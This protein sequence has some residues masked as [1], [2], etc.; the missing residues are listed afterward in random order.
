MIRHLHPGS[1]SIAVQTPT[2]LRLLCVFN[3]T[4]KQR[5]PWAFLLPL[6]VLPLC[7]C[8]TL[9]R[10]QPCV[11]NPGCTASVHLIHSH[12]VG[13]L[14]TCQ[15]GCINQQVRRLYTAIGC[16]PYGIAQDEATL[17]ADAEHRWCLFLTTFMCRHYRMLACKLTSCSLCVATT[18]SSSAQKEGIKR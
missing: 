15:C 18:R 17:Q 13:A 8:H 4:V 6:M 12:T 1:C 14:S 11:V 2:C 3:T 9:C 10:G 7:K 5:M 16:L